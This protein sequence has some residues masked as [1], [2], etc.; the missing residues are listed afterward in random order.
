M[1]L[2][3]PS[4]VLAGL[5]ALAGCA[6]AN[7]WTADAESDADADADS[8]ADS[9]S[10][11]DADSDADS[12]ADGGD[13]ALPSCT[14]GVRNGAEEGVDCGGPCPSCVPV[15][16]DHEVGVRYHSLVGAPDAF[17]A[18]FV[19]DYHL[20]DN[21]AIAVGQMQAMVDGGVSVIHL[22]IWPAGGPPAS[23]GSHF[24]LSGQEIANLASFVADVRGLRS[25]TT[26]NAPRL[27]LS[28][29]D[30]GD[31]G[32]KTQQ[33]NDVF[34]IAAGGSRDGGQFL[35]AWRQTI[36]DIV[37]A[38]EPIRH[39]D[40]TP[41]LE[42]IYLGGE[43]VLR[44]DG[45][46]P[47][48]GPAGW[49][50]Q[51]TLVNLFPDFWDACRD[52][53]I[54]PSTYLFASPIVT[55]RILDGSWLEAVESTLRW[56]AAALP[57]HQ[58]DRVDVSVY[59][60]DH[61]VPD[62]TADQRERILVTA[63]GLDRLTTRLFGPAGRDYAFVEAHYYCVEADHPDA[64]EEA[65]GTYRDM[66]D[67]GHPDHHPRFRGTHVWPYPYSIGGGPNVNGAAPPFDLSA[68]VP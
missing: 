10:D 64:R 57:D 47:Y 7:V 66:L 43:V 59:T 48:D 50:L 19:N 63:D 54:E 52:A 40:G 46:S 4:L 29:L 20:G 34:P 21:R 27:H 37:D 18:T 15:F 16:A 38:V 30:A 65:F 44:E 3:V 33:V 24:P 55:R 35:E 36:R 26:G 25:A 67:P 41:V 9:D 51:W 28:L 39:G 49:V 45:S 23:W 11:A 14:D 17:G 61:S 8:D 32:Y 22:T 31:S 53:G 5:A 60:G 6:P 1:R 68:M 56:W 2:A 12:D 13:A 42:R 62:Y 58:P